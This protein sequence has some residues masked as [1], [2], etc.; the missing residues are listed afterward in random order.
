MTFGA[1][2]Y[3]L[4]LM[5]LQLL[6]ETIYDYAYRFVGHPGL[7]IIALSLA[8]N[9]LV[10]PLYMRADAMQ[11]EQRNTEAK[12]SKGISHIRKTFRGDERTM[13]LQTYYRQNNY[14]PLSALRGATSLLLEIP[15][16]IAAYRF[17]SGLSLLQGVSFGPIADLSQPDGLI[18]I[19]GLAINLLPILMTAINLVSSAIF[20]KD[21]PL[22][23]KIQLYAMSAIFLVLL[24]KSPSGLVFYWTLNNAFSLVKTVFYKLKN[25]GKVIRIL[26]CV[27]GLGVIAAAGLGLIPLR[28]SYRIV[29]MGVGVLLCVPLLLGALKNKVKLPT[30]ETRRKPNKKLFVTGVLLLAVLVGLLIP[31]ALIKASPQ[32]FVDVNYFV[33]PLWYVANAL[34]VAIGTFLLWFNV[35][36]WLASPKAKVIFDYGIWIICAMALVDYLFFGTKLGNISSNLIFDNPIHFSGKQMLLNIISIVIAAAVIFLCIRKKE[37]VVSRVFTVAVA[38]IFCMA[39]INVFSIRASVADVNVESLSAEENIPHITLSKTGKNVVVIMLDRAMGEYVPYIFN[40]KP[41]LKEQFAG[42]TY[43]D[44]VISF[45]ASTNFGTPALFGGYEYTPVEINKRDAESLAEKQNEA[46]KMMPALFDS[47]GFDVTVMDPPYAGYQ[48]T[49]DLS[50]YDDYPG[51]DTYISQGVFT[52][53]ELKEQLAQNRFRNLFCYGLMKI[54]PVCLQQTLYDVGN[55]HQSQSEYGDQIVIS[56]HSAHGIGASFD[57]S[58]SVLKQLADMTTISAADNGT[59]T[60]MD[61]ET[62]HFSTLLQEPGYEDVFAVDNTEYDAQNTDRFTVDGKTL[63]VESAEEYGTYQVNMASFLQLGKWLDDLRENGVYDNTKIIL[64]SDHGFGLHQMESLFIDETADSDTRSYRYGD[65]ESY[66]PLLMV[67]D[68]NSTEFTTSDEFMTNADVPTLAVADVISD[69][70]NPFT[71]N[72][73]DSSEKTAHDQMVIASADSDIATNNGNRFHSARWYSVHDSIWDKSNWTLVAEDAVLPQTN[74]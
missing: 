45:G 13:M 35:F 59:F 62:T 25:P 29:L 21:Y 3:S 36:Y 58:Y 72:A 8:I 42:F 15:F 20:S 61:N 46:L 57:N 69:P 64:V 33:H 10:L 53:T 68:F 18:V 60:M 39:V 56:N 67:K 37:T 48:W 70:I 44:N 2:L 73:I 47:E 43:Y 71:G 12:L 16:F 30:V 52:R 55:Y 51:I 50:I 54:C 74:K 26:C 6:F 32:E 9:I 24:Y 41:Q 1:C 5:P 66:F 38:A 23:T 63:R 7:A 31:S 65:V 11:E 4:V 19:G 14:S 27:L 49:P 17:L 28:R 40:E 22:K 34:L